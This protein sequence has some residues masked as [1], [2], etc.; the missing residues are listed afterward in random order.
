MIVPENQPN[1][2]PKPAAAIGRLATAAGLI[3]SN[4]DARKIDQVN[5]PTSRQRINDYLRDNPQATKTEIAAGLGLSFGCV[6]RYEPELDQPIIHDKQR[7]LSRNRQSILT[8]IADNPSTSVREIATKTNLAQSTVSRH[9][10]ILE[11]RLPNKRTSISDSNQARIENWARNHPEM[12][13]VEIAKMTGLS[14]STVSRH[15]SDQSNRPTKKQ[16]KTALINQRRIKSYIANN[17]N[18]TQS[19]IAQALDLSQSTVSRHLD[20]LGIAVVTD[21]NRT[22]QNNQNQIKAYMDENPSAIQTE[23]G[24][25]LGLS[26]ATVSRHRK[27]LG[28]SPR[29]KTDRDRQRINDYLEENPDASSQEISRSLNLPKSTIGRHLRTI[30]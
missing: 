9:L 11:I 6:K 15:L 23:V 8:A 18:Q 19:E 3:E 16:N 2:E 27:A 25:A 30:R 4:K 28:R 5:P 21:S 13:Q 12:T 1:P 26:Q 29:D 14:E 22:A 24:A 20:V 7:T 17:P 10:K